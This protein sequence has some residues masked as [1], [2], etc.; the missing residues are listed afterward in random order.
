MK[1]VSSI[2]RFFLGG[3]CGFN[4]DFAFAVEAGV[5]GLAI[6]YL[7]AFIWRVYSTAK[8]AAQVDY[9]VDIFLGFGIGWNAIILLHCFRSGVVGRQGFGGVAAESI[10]QLA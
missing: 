6:C 2:R 7:P 3:G 5:F 8:S 10:E 9:F 1:K 4:G